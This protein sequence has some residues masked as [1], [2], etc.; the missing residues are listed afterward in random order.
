MPRYAITFTEP[1]GQTHQRTVH[2]ASPDDAIELAVRKLWTTQAY[3]QWASMSDTHGRVLTWHGREPHPETDR[4]LTGA[5]TA[6]EVRTPAGQVV[7]MPT[8]TYHPTAAS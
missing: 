2:A 4:A 8:L 1:T 5:H 3:W 6:V 7:P